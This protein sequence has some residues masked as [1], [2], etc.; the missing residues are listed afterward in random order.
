MAT[1][2]DIVLLDDVFSAL[3][4]TTK[5]HIATRLLGPEGLLR[6]LGTTVLFATHDC[7][8]GEFLNCVQRIC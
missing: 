7:K 5:H 8:S 6:R 1:R 4:R 3:D 2:K